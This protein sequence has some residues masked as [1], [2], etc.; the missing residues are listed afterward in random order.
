[1]AHASEQD[2]LVAGSET[3][4]AAETLQSLQ[5]DLHL[6][7]EAWPMGACD[8]QLTDPCCLNGDARQ[9]EREDKR[10]DERRTRGRTREGTRGGRENRWSV[11]GLNYARPGGCTVYC[12]NFPAHLKRH[13]RFAEDWV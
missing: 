12:F 1:M 7:E 3:A 6:A 9:D 10:E 4:A 13:Y 5:H 11:N 8:R 2:V